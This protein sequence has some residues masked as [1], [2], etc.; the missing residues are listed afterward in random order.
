M[1]VAFGDRHKNLV[2]RKVSYF[3]SKMF[4]GSGDSQIT[5]QA[6]AVENYF[7]FDCFGDLYCGDE[8]GNDTFLSNSSSAILI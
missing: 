8:K 7:F 1:L 2:L 3:L 4:Q 5:F 6:N